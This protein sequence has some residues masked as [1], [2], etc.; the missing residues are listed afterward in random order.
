SSG[1]GAG[2][3]ATRVERAVSRCWFG[4]VRCCG[5]ALATSR[6]RAGWAAGRTTGGEGT[7]VSFRGAG[8]LVSAVSRK[9]GWVVDEL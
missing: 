4:R 5:R 7:A 3:S 8:A 1:S 6:R 2:T 9:I